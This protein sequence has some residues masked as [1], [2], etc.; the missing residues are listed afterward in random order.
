MPH[1]SSK[2]PL[3]PF[4]RGTALVR[5]YLLL[6]GKHHAFAGFVTWITQALASLARIRAYNLAVPTILGKHCLLDLLSQV[7]PTASTGGNR[8]VRLSVLCRFPKLPVSECVQTVR[9]T[10]DGG[11]STRAALERLA[12]CR[13]ALIAHHAAMHA[14]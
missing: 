14:H 8:C 4:S 13:L 12:F 6:P 3:P 7:F 10:Q 5:V 1:L 2:P 9:T 11:L